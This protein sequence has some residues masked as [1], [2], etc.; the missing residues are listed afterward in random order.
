MSDTRPYAIKLNSGTKIRLNSIYQT[1]TY[2]G[3]MMGV[4]NEYYN[5]RMVERA[6]TFTDWPE[7]ADPSVLTP[8]ETFLPEAEVPDGFPSELGRPARLPHV[9]CRALFHGVSRKDRD[10]HLTAMVIHWWQD[11]LAMPISDVA[12]E[13]IRELDWDVL[14]IGLTD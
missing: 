8:Q 11:E 12:I 6:G 5:K 2:A 14:A 3:L 9:F 7:V 10:E 13:Q 4:P 1:Y